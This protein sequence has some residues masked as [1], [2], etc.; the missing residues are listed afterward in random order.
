MQFA[1]Y[2]GHEKL[3]TFSNDVGYL[4]DGMPELKTGF[5]HLMRF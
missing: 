5:P 2:D 4:L 1:S 3:V